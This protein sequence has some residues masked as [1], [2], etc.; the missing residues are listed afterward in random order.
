MKS[1]F[2]KSIAL[3]LALV[4]LMGMLAGLSLIHI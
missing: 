2:K 4:M 3:L 1:N